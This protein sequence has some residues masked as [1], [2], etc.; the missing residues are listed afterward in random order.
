MEVLSPSYQPSP[1]FAFPGP[2][3]FPDIE[4]KR[5]DLFVEVY[6]RSRNCLSYRS[7]GDSENTNIS[8]G[9]KPQCNKGIENHHIQKKPMSQGRPKSRHT[10][11][12]PHEERQKRLPP[13]GSRALPPIENAT[14]LAGPFNTAP[15]V[16]ATRDVSAQQPLQNLANPDQRSSRPI[17]VQNLLN[18]TSNGK[19]TNGHLQGSNGEYLDTPAIDNPP[20]TAP[21]A[22]TPALPMGPLANRSPASV[23]LP[24]ITPPSINAYPHQLG[25]SPSAYAPSPI[26][27]GN[28]T[29]TMDVKQSPFVLPRDHTATGNAGLS[30]MSRL[31]SMSSE[32]Y[33]VNAIAPRSPPVRRGS[34]DSSRYDRIQGLLGRTGGVGTGAHPAASQSDSPSTQYSSYSQVSRQTPPVQPSASIG[35]PQSFFTPFSAGGPAT[36]MAQMSFD[37]TSSGGSGGG[38]SYQMMTLDTENG[39][40]QVPVDVQAASKV[41]DEKRKRNATASHRFRQRR[42]EKE[43]ETSQNIAKLEQQAR[44]LEEERDFYRGERDYFRSISSRLPGQAHLMARPV[45]PRQ[46]RHASLGGALAYGS[47][48]HLQEPEDGNRSGGRNTR[49]RTSSYMPPSGPPPQAEMPP[50]LPLYQPPP[51][52]VLELNRGKNMMLSRP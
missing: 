23:S 43:R 40:I 10:S 52:K 14:T 1:S 36:T 3:P 39:P 35:Q 25:R 30:G 19:T 42:K 17:G 5:P 28:P 9:S 45:S 33:P 49:R 38:N 12:S 24:S 41:A 13:L 18:P 31:P 44:E 34:Q 29:A 50:T 46:R 7:C 16:P 21:R 51:P 27:M 6:N 20:A 32:P 4:S 47:S 15:N 2:L 11:I 26:L 37:A 8:R 48:L 22:S